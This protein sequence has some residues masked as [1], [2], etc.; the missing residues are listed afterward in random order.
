MK[1]YYINY[2]MGE[3]AIGKTGRIIEFFLWLLFHEYKFNLYKYFESLE[4]FKKYER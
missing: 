3:R 4:V 1:K 2:Y